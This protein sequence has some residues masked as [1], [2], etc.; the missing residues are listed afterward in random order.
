MLADSAPSP[1]IP[2]IANR[3]VVFPLTA[4]T[5]VTVAPAM[6]LRARS[7][8]CSVAGLNASLQLTSYVSAPGGER[9]PR[10]RGGVGGGGA[11]GGGEKKTRA[12][13]AGGGRDSF[14][15]RRPP[16]PMAMLCGPSTV[17]GLTLKWKVIVS[18]VPLRA[19]EFA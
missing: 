10:G 5:L 14:R 4:V 11:G 2:P 16:P 7:D 19:K 8:V 3:A 18:P 15:P 13:R 6:P 12:A 17:T 1:E 9:A